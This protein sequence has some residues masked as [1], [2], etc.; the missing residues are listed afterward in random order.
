VHF[1]LNRLTD[2]DEL[3][4]VALID[5]RMYMKKKNPGLKYFKGDN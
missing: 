1:L 4:T 5:L 3:Y 2:S